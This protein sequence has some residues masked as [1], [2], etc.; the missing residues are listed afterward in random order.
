MNL[1]A[2][3]CWFILGGCLILFGLQVATGFAPAHTWALYAGGTISAGI[4]CILR[5]AGR[6]T[7]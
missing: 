6:P 1:L 7:S 4:L 3:I 2:Q 5:G